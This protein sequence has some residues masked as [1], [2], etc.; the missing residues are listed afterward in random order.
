MLALRIRKPGE[1]ATDTG[2][3]RR[4]RFAKVIGALLTKPTAR[5]FVDVESRWR[6]LR[7]HGQNSVKLFCVI[8]SRNTHAHDAHATGGADVDALDGTTTETMEAYWGEEVLTAQTV[9]VMVNGCVDWR[10][11][12][13][14]EEEMVV[15]T[16]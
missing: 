1:S 15:K 8:D 7:R 13:L 16:R 6:R 9:A 4:V 11:T 12:V 5:I 3:A 10:I 2:S 14:M